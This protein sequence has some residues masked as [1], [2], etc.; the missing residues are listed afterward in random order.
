V[1]ASR[2]A[3]ELGRVVEGES[4]KEGFFLMRYNKAEVEVEAESD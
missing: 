1:V 3:K 4:E 2:E